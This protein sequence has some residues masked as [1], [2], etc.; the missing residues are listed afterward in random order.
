M[1]ILN[2]TKITDSRQSTPPVI[3]EA[4][5]Y[6]TSKV[7][8]KKQ[9]KVSLKKDETNL[10]ILLNILFNMFLRFIINA[11][12]DIKSITYL[13]INNNYFVFE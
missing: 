13:I 1:F 8:L 12:R 6:V 7:F 5:E 10:I 2:I 11:P 4:L 3:F 9:G